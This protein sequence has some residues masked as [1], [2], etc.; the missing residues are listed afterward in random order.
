MIGYHLSCEEH[1]PRDLVQFAE[2]AEEAG[3]GFAQISDHFHP[4]TNHQGQSPF[5]WG[6]LGAIAE[7]TEK[8]RVGTAVTCP[9][10]RLHPAITAQAVA[11]AALQL[12][13]RFFLGV[14]SG[15]RLNEAV[16]GDR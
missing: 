7:R 4:W 8:I 12:E 16:L 6:V 11:T 5:V 1:G 15:E 2:R 10:I 14:G 3:F 13:D 9:T